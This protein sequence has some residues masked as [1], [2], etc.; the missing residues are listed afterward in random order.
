MNGDNMNVYIKIFGI[1]SLM[2]YT[3]GLM[4]I[5][6][7]SDVINN[8]TYFLIGESNCYIKTTEWIFGGIGLIIGSYMIQNE[9]KNIA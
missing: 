3:F 4:S 1:A 2:A 8:T 5:W 6:I 7:F 9:I